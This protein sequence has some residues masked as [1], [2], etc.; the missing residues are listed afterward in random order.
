MEGKP[1]TPCR[2]QKHIALD[3]AI[4]RLGEVRRRVFAILRE[5]Q[6]VP[7]E[8]PPDKD[9]IK[10]PSPTLQEVLDGGPD[11]IHSFCESIE[12]TLGG[13]KQSIF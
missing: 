2:E 11:R 10:S 4:N 7:E 5:I 3:G 12:G 1:D 13:I 6:G 9:S 8:V